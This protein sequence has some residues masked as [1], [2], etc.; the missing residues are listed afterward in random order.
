[1]LPVF[2]DDPLFGGIPGPGITGSHGLTDITFAGQRLV[3]PHSVL[4]EKAT[5]LDGI[6]QREDTS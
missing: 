2:F 6:S 4:V 5:G 3:M 1:M